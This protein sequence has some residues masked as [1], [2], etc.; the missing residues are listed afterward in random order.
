MTAA[1]LGMPADTLESLVRGGREL[2]IKETSEQNAIHSTLIPRL[3][4]VQQQLYDSASMV[5]G[6]QQAENSDR[7]L[8][9]VTTYLASQL[10]I[11]KCALSILHSNAKT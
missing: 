5:E 11:C 4:N 3:M 10:H 2:N 8:S 6:L 7:M 9:R 1:V